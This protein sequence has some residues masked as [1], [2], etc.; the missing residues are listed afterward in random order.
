MSNI[1]VA[2]ASQP[3]LA[4]R[5]VEICEHKGLAHPDSL[6]DGAA[7]AAAQA[8]ARA[9]MSA[10][11][12][13]QHFNVDKGLLVAGRSEP[14]FDGGTILVPPKLVLCGRAADADDRFDVTE[15]ILAAARQYLKGVLPESAEQ[16]VLEAAIHQGSAD[17]E[18]LYRTDAEA[19]ANDTSV[20]VGFAPLSPLERSVLALAAALR[21]PALRKRF[22]A[23]GK[24]FKIM[25]VRHGGAMSYTLGLAMIGRHLHSAEHYHRTK[26]EIA[27]YLEEHVPG[28]SALV[29]NASDDPH[30]ENESGLYVTVTGSSSEMGDDGQVGRG[31]RVNGLITPGRAMSL[32][33]V[34]GKNPAGHVGKIYNVLA[35]Q[36]A[37]E[38]CEKVPEA[39]EA[40]VQL[41]SQIGRPV[42][43]PWTVFIEIVP[44]K[45]MTKGV[46]EHIA[47]L[48]RSALERVGELSARLAE[49]GAG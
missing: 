29:I 26:Q 34:A 6:A 17:L 46:S 15:V 10:F 40:S 20:G 44:A 25:G 2:E 48:A 49:H 32:E 14:R 7:E 9:Y 16:F 5:K 28:R 38:I 24:D 4:E 21:D 8:L 47:G 22:P 33:A 45:E 30:A 39:A 13:V 37:R 3:A 11:G 27:A 1:F 43:Q 18:R 41:V 31:N 23:A 12:S 35:E 42:T 36:L 19:L